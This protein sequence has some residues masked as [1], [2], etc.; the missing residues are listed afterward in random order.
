VEEPITRHRTFP[1][2]SK[3]ILE[4]HDRCVLVFSVLLSQDRGG[5]IDIFQDVGIVDN[6]LEHSGSDRFRVNLKREL[7]ENSIPNPDRVVEEFEQAKWAFLP[8]PLKVHMQRNFLGGKFV[9]PYCRRQRINHKGG[10]AAV[11]EVVVQ[12]EFF[13]IPDET[14]DEMKEVLRRSLFEDS[15]FGEVRRVSHYRDVSI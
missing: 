10:T 9:F 12:K 11:Y 6:S 5:L 13:H 3:S 8:A 7:R 2:T 15:E 14:A 4:G 1:I